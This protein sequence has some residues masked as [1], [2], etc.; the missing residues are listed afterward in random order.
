MRFK[1]KGYRDDFF[2]TVRCPIGLD[3]VPGKLPG[4]V[5][6]SIAGEIISEYHLD[7]PNQSRHH[8]GNWQQLKK[9]QP[10]DKDLS[11]ADKQD[12]YQ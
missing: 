8:T 10:Q 7:Q 3:N 1:H 11:V 6:V 4:E 9:N 12:L 2:S 5:A